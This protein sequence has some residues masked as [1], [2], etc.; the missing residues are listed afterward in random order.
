MMQ[1]G[2]IVF[3]LWSLVSISHAETMIGKLQW[4]EKT[5][6]NAAVSGRIEKISVKAGEL[7]KQGGLLLTIEQQ[8]YQARLLQAKAH[9]LA[10]E[11]AAAEVE[12]EMNNAAELFE[13]TVISEH[14]FV[15][16]KNAHALAQ[17]QMRQ[18]QAS[19][20][21]AQNNQIQSQLH[22]PFDAWV[23]KI[24]A[25]ENQVVDL[26]HQ[27]W[28]LV[29]IA[30]AGYMQVEVHLNP[31]QRSQIKIGQSVKVK[32]SNKNYNAF[33]DQAELSASGQGDERL[34]RVSAIFQTDKLLLPGQ[35]AE[36]S[37]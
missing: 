12:R 9:M 17:A 6:L 37:F 15:L 7:I 21:A 30:R 33:V 25:K 32:V 14:E 20:I 35:S 5:Q 24:L 36:L 28:P 10:Q 29:E 16:A 22:A 23:L 18:A 2:F 8:L 34:F 3:L 19:L 4:A 1:R 27:L 13:R 31:Q 26:Q 11:Q